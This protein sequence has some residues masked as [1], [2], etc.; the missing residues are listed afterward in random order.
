MSIIMEEDDRLIEDVNEEVVPPPF[1]YRDEVQIT[2]IN[3][4]RHR[5]IDGIEVSGSL[6]SKFV[7]HNNA[8]TSDER[9]NMLIKSITDK[10][11]KAS[12]SDVMQYELTEVNKCKS[13][14]GQDPIEINGKL[15]DTFFSL[16]SDLDR[17][18]T[19]DML[20]Q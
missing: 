5:L 13:G 10:K 1:L 2:T 18:K 17:N 14:T 4:S 9:K 6:S 7:K 15:H 8:P 16:K 12:T 3:D 20:P 19:L 11:Y